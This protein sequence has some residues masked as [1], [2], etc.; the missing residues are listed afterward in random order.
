[1]EP[2]ANPDHELKLQLTRVYVALTLSR[3]VAGQL[4]A[5]NPND[6]TARSLSTL[7]AV[8]SEMLERLLDPKIQG[9]PPTIDSPIEAN[10]LM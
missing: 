6:K 5:K 9:Q 2:E 8:T 1:M 10:H 3:N 4:I 7:L